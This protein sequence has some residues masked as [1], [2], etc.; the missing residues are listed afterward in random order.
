M[1]LFQKKKGGG[2]GLVPAALCDGLLKQVFEGD[3]QTLSAN[4]GDALTYAF[5]LDKCPISINV[6]RMQMGKGTSK[7]MTSSLHLSC[8]PCMPV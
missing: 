5:L 6:D 1:L 7:S 3:N 2:E 8:M 4:S